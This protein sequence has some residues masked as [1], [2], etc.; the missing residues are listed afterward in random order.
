MLTEWHKLLML[1]LAIGNICLVWTEF[2]TNANDDHHQASQ[3]SAVKRS[4]NVDRIGCR[5]GRSSSHCW[6]LW[7]FT[8]RLSMASGRH[9]L[10]LCGNV[11]MQPPSFRCFRLIE[12]L[13]TLD[14]CNNDDRPSTRHTLQLP[15][16]THLC[17]STQNTYI[18]SRLDK[19][20]SIENPIDRQRDLFNWILI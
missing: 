2:W 11:W 4:D 18:L 10:E 16:T 13:R 5:C 12:C 17:S 9:L 7:D 15:L 3:A 8:G 20:S 6:V 19:N 1:V 14:L